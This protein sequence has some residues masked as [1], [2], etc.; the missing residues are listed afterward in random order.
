MILEDT[1][2]DFMQSIYDLFF[3]D[4]DNSRAN[5]IIDIFDI[6]TENC[7]ELPCKVGDEVYYILKDKMDRNA[8]NGFIVSEPSKITE[9]GT[10][11]FW[12]SVFPNEH[13]D[14]MDDF[15]PWDSIGK[16]VKLV[17]IL[18]EK[19]Y[20]STTSKIDFGDVIYLVNSQPTIDMQ[21]TDEQGVKHGKWIEKHYEG[22]IFDG[23]NLDECSVCGYERFIDDVKYKTE[24][25][26]CPGCGAK[27]DGK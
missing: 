8:I 11:G 26:F 1:R 4:C 6:A 20:N 14:A 18:L 13:P 24:Y 22:G 5:Q 9:I 21:T 19:N 25:K 3:D 23:S 27:M 17:G 2:N 15:E 10:R 7:I 12:T 16:T